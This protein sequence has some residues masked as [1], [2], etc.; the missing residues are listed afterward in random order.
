MTKE[1]HLVAVPSK[2]GDSSYYPFPMMNAVKGS[3]WAFWV[4]GF[5]PEELDRIIALGDALDPKQATTMGGVTGETLK[6][7]R[8]SNVAWLRLSPETSWIYERMSFIASRLN[9]DFFGFDINGVFD[10]QYTVYR[11]GGEHYD[12]HVD[13][14]SAP[15]D[16][17]RKLSCTLQLSDPFDYEGGE[18]MIHSASKEVLSKNRG[19]IHAFPS[20]ALHRVSPVTSGIRKS[21][22]AWFVGPQFK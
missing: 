21:L 9:S 2:D 5:T 15:A 12:W 18:L 19:I 13:M 14:H 11:E 7:I 1:K 6:K 22:V 17:Q 3:P 20:Y 4:D 8:N 16:M 10:L